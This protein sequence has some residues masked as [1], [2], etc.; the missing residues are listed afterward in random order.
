MAI[1]AIGFYGADLGAAFSGQKSWH[2]P[3]VEATEV[4]Q[5]QT[6]LT[7]GYQPSLSAN[8]I[9]LSHYY[10]GFIHVPQDR[11]TFSSAHGRR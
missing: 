3:E 9:V 4:T 2:E 10:E 1:Q 6:G 11:I 5:S 8:L 7:A